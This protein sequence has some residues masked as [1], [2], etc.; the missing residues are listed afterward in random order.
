[1]T[2]SKHL[3]ITLN[4]VRKPP[5]PESRYPR[6]AELGDE[7]CVMRFTLETLVAAQGAIGDRA[8]HVAANRR[9][10]LVLGPTGGKL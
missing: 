1:M 10:R 6:F 5:D 7:R 2:A 4:H 3:L 9:Q 8:G